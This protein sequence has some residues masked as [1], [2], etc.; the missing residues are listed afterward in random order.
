MKSFFKKLAFVMALAMVV[1]MAAPAAQKAVAAEDK[2]PL[3][4][5]Y[6]EGAAIKT[7]N[8]KN[9]GDEEDLRFLYAPANYKE[10]GVT[11]SSS[12][13]NVVSVDDNGLVKA[14]AEGN[15]TISVAIGTETASIDVYC[16][17][18]KTFEATIGTPENREMET[19]TIK[20]GDYIDFA[21]YGIED[22]SANR[23]NCEWFPVDP[24]GCI[25]VC[26]F[27]TATPGLVTA[28][29][30]G[31]AK[32]TLAVINLKTMQRTDVKSVTI[33]EPATEPE[34]TPAPAM[35]VLNTRTKTKVNKTQNTVELVFDKATDLKPE[36]VTLFRS[37][38]MT[39]HTLIFS[40]LF[41]HYIT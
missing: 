3:A 28:K 21:F 4:I 22:Y 40:G 6:Q 36:N 17:N 15:A 14:E 32:L 9:V 18:M 11:W 34:V 10:L 1:S 24:E 37:T 35:E 5:A 29:K 30:A 16:V 25:E 7:L 38:M 19:A 41:L 13:P 20:V 12:N 39:Q 26:G 33:T 31:T 2:K 27:D 23:Y 8:L